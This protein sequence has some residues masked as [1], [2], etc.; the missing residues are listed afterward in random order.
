ME[1]ELIAGRSGIYGHF[2]GFQPLVSISMDNYLVYEL[3][4]KQPRISVRVSGYEFST[5][6]KNATIEAAYKGEINGTP[7]CRVSKM[8]NV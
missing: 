8:H 4:P 7:G 1:T 5:I 3:S 2:L 6:K